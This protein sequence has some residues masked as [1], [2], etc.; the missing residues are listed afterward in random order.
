M[1]PL[2][3]A[4][5]ETTLFTVVQVMVLLTS[6]V[7]FPV[8]T[9]LLTVAEY[10]VLAIAITTGMLLVGFAKCG[11]S[12]A[13]VR[14]HAAVIQDDPH[15]VTALV[16]TAFWSALSIA[17]VVAA[18]YLALCGLFGPLPHAMSWK[19]VPFVALTIVAIAMRD[20]YYAYLRAEQ[21]T[22]RVNIVIL[23]LR[24]GAVGTGLTLCALLDDR[25]WGFLF[26]SV[27]WEASLVFLLWLSVA[28][29][30][31]LRP[32]GFS[33]SSAHGLVK[34]GAPLVV[35][36]V[37]SLANDYADRYLI[38][39]LIGVEYVGVYS[40]GYNLANYINIALVYPMWQAVFP[41]L[42][43][44]WEEE[45][46][47]A[48]ERFLSQILSAYIFVAGLVALLVLTNGRNLL[49]LLASTKFEQ[50]AQIFVAVC[51]VMLLYGSTWIL[52]AGLHLQRRTGQLAGMMGGAAA[53]N[54]ALNWI[55][56]PKFGLLGAVYA[57]I[58]SYSLL[59]IAI[60]MIGRRQVSVG[61]PMN[62][63]TTVVGA[64]VVGLLICS[65]FN[66]HGLVQSLLLK[67]CLATLVYSIIVLAIDKKMRTLAARAIE[68]AMRRRATGSSA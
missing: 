6:L 66:I 59:T 18:L 58:V 50:S 2:Q 11:L 14:E 23:A 33:W 52:G 7:S 17:G 43:R 12:T 5:R 49:V 60:T 25:L 64:I 22:W 35:F 26:G 24:V 4:I 19:I 27:T 16:S 31:S 36:E 8:L 21:R 9:R 53:V 56:I 45:G 29:E 38:A 15:A 44:L 61:A 65:A 55:F 40:V 63:M 67:G 39:Y 68:V 51:L 34:Y 62:T 28:R 57:T 3:K 10:G 20:L 41:I 54:I 47:A 30:R 1:R 46:K 13:F 37:A 32:G 48:T 42:S